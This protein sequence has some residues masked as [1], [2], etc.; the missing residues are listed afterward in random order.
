MV[1]VTCN[2]S[3][4][5]ILKALSVECVFVDTY[6]E[7]SIFLTSGC[8]LLLDVSSTVERGYGNRAALLFVF[9]LS[10]HSFICDVWD[11]LFRR[12]TLPDSTH[13][14][15][16]L[17]HPTMVPGYVWLEWSGIT[18]LMVHLCVG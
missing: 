18:L 4:F 3:T 8:G 17:P 5:V 9:L 11:K 14:S 12:S 7:S 6:G 13:L 16:I 2:V 1:L 15:H 10:W